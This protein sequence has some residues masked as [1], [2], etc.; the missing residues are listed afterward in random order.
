MFTSPSWFAFAILA[1]PA[2]APSQPATTGQ[3]GATQPAQPATAGQPAKGEA[4]KPAATAAAADP[5]A[6]AKASV[7]ERLKT[8]EKLYKAKKYVDSARELESLW[9]DT[10][11]PN[12]LY[13]AALARFAAGHY[14]HAIA[15]LEQY[16]ADVK[17][18]PQEALEL[19]QFQLEKAKERSAEVPL[20]IGPPEAVAFGAEVIVRRVAT[21]DKDARPELTFAVPAPASATPAARS[22]YLDAGRWSVETRAKGYVSQPQDVVVGKKDKAVDGR[23]FVLALDPKLRQVS[24]RI[25]VPADAQVEAVEVEMRS[26]TDTSAPP[27]RC[28]IRPFEA[29]E[30]RLLTEIGTWEV[31]ASAPGFKPFHQVITL[32]SGQNPAS[33]TLPLASDAPVAA[34]PPPDVEPEKIDVVPKPV[35]MRVAGALNASGLPIFVTGLGLAVYGSNTYD[36]AINTDAADCSGALDN[37]N[38]RNDT[39]KAIRLRTAGLALIGTATGLFTTGLTAEF[40][41]KPRVWYAEMG[42]GGGLLLGGAIWLGATTASLNRELMVTDAPPWEQSV[43]NIDKAT[44]QR[45]A[46]AMLMGTGIGLVTGSTV[47]LLIRKRYERR[48]KPLKTAKLSPFAPMGGG[49]VMLSGRF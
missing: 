17:D 45:L 3:P 14:T 25:D 7:D 18:A 24:L 4:A 12:A 39:I 31:T 46:G 2:S 1:A 8:A 42:V 34:V 47:G 36:R 9:D 37:Y 43:P 41:V 35:R 20:M 11:H 38:C 13:N 6:A 22:I 10:Q 44:N 28:T 49:G 30:C 33:Y 40:D 27:Q 32:T 19:A 16:V 26:T 15:Y 5:G 21:N 29:N 48:A 23:T